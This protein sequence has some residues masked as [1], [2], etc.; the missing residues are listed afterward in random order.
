MYV[1]ANKVSRKKINEDGRLKLILAIIFLLAAGIIFKL[2]SLQVF[3]YDFYTAIASDQHDVFSKLEPERG[4]III[5]DKQNDIGQAT[6]PIALNKEFALVYAIPKIITDPEDTAQKLYEILDADRVKKMV[7][8][9]IASEEIKSKKTLATNAT[10]IIKLSESEIKENEDFKNIKKELEMELKKKNIILEYK[11]KFL[12]P[13]DPYE[14][15]SYKV[16]EE[17]LNKIKD[18]N[19]KGIDYIMQMD[20]FYPE[21]GLGGQL[22]GFVGYQGDNKVGQYGLEGYFNEELTGKPGSIKAERSANGELIIINDREYKKAE[23][24]NDLLLTIDRSIQFISCSK[25]KEA[26]MRHGADSGSVIVLEPKTGAILAMCSYPDYNPN[27]YTDVSDINIYN[28]PAIFSQYE[29]GSI[30]KA[31]TMAAS[32]DQGKVTPETTYNDKGSVMIDGW[33]KPIKNSDFETRGGRGIV[34]MI[35]VLEQSLNTGVIFAMQKAGP[36]IFVDYLKKFGFGEKTGIEM[37]TESTGSLKNLA[38]KKIKPIEAATASFGQGL[39]VTPLQMVN[40]YAAIANGGILMKPYLVK[41]ITKS[42]GD[43]IFTQPRE[44]R[45]VISERT[46]ALL[47]GM[48]VKVVENGHGKKAGVAGYY[49]AGKTGTAQVPKK[50]GGYEESA[51][52][53]SFAGFGPVDDPAFVMLVKID[54]PRDV[55]W[56]ESSAAPLFGEIAQF[57]LNYYQIPKER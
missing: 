39:T 25:I 49:I 12:K 11:A 43:K 48:L 57:I 2:Y 53:G 8:N 47:G 35:T 20:R 5:S 34:N 36:D 27:E 6:H 3:K 19:I 13:N 24:G 32:L 16:S 30:F 21:P 41:E 33:P 52:I 17:K 10:E 26:V 45:R 23:N 28:N 56:A 44:I 18:L 4:K 31:M 14:P 50:G 51:H 38:V 55:E 54:N 9:E 42:N 29:P 37:E 46:A 22:I 15:I 40:A 7:E 1:R